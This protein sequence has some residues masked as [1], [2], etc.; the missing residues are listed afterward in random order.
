MNSELKGKE[1][2][3]EKEHDTWEKKEGREYT[4]KLACLTRN[5]FSPSENTKA[6]SLQS[7]KDD[8]SD[9]HSKPLNLVD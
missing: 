4:A 8:Y 1:E 6:H 5:S 7:P 3:K 2:R 9:S